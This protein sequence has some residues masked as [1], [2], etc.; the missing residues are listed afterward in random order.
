MSKEKSEMQLA[1]ERI[2][3][4]VSL[5][6]GK[7]SELGNYAFSLNNVL[8]IIQKQFDKI[9]NVSSDT[10]RKYE[11]AK[12]IRIEWKQQVDKIEY[13]YNS[14]TKVELSTGTAGTGLGVGVAALAPT[15]AMSIATTF[16]VASTGTA[17]STLSGAAATNAALAWLGGGTL[18]AGGGGMAGGTALLALAGPVGWS[19]AGAA[20][21]GSGLMLWIT[22]SNKNRLEEVFKQIC[23]RDE[24]KYKLAI[25]ELNERIKRII[26][27]TAKLNDAIVEIGSFGIDYENMTEQ[28]QY[29]LGAY[30]NLMYASSQLL[31]NPIMGLQPNYTEKDLDAFLSSNKVETEYLLKKNIAV[32]FANLLYKIET[33]EKDRKLLAKSFKGNKQFREQMKFEK[34]DIDLGLFNLVDRAL[35]FSY[36]N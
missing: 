7:I 17:I 8:T 32:Y 1:A 34:K 10:K 36:K 30:V 13:D 5:T 14:A 3:S 23:D 21:L 22:K 33:D 9:R 12:E 26:D 4:L 16:G 24:N 19:L 20:I 28:Q 25:I 35:K 2:A 18:A 27:E 15:A 29:T 11:Q 31:V 6:N